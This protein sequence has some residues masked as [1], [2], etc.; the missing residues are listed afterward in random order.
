MSKVRPFLDSTDVVG[1]TTE[2]H[3]RF[4]RDG[5]LFI[6][7]LLPVAVLDDLRQ[8]FNKLLREA[9]W[10]AADAPLD[11]PI[12]DLRAFAV[13][14]EPAYQAVYNQLYGVPAFHALQHRAEFVDIME[15][16]LDGPVMPHPRTIVRIMFPKKTAHTTPAHQDFIPVQGATDT[17]TAWIPLTDLPPEMGGL[18][19]AA[20]SHR[21]GVFDFVPAL[22]AGGMVI[23]DSFDDAWVGGTFEQGDVL[24]FH[25]MTVHRGAPATGERLRLSVDYRFQR[26]A[27][28]IT[29]ASLEPHDRL[30]DW[31]QIYADW[32][33]GQYQYFWRNWDLS[34]TEYD[35]QYN[36]KRDS[37]AFE[38]AANG[39]ETARASLNRIVARDPDPDKKLRAAEAIESLNTRSQ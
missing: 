28:P 21:Q 5:Y 30:I 11:D 16:L 34:I 33:P 35:M 10:I 22:G 36:E 4:D 14:P 7:G 13:E 23:T 1:D 32:A 29:K 12:A 24:L 6:R 38:L 9:G 26:R 19:I 17:V 20:G 2:L 39:D 37:L 18:E 31:E 27:D 3:M 15:R 8:E 25:S